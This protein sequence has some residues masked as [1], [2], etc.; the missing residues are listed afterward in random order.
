MKNKIDKDFLI[1]FEN[2]ICT[3]FNDKRIKS[4][5]HLHSGNEVELI[6]IFKKIKKGLIF[7]SWRSHYHCLLKGV[8]EKT[9]KSNY[10]G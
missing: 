8:S 10:W 6:K 5:I 7:C 9:N 1:N 2:K 4:P 3:L